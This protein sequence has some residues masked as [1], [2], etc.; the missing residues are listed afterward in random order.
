MR[1]KNF[2]DDDNFERWDD[3]SDY[4]VDLDG[5]A[6]S[7]DFDIDTL[8]ESLDFDVSGLGRDLNFD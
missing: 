1:K 5:L 6:G 3:F 2:L 8:T 7:L 4:D